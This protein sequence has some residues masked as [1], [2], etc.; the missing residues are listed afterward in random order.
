MS[1]ITN[2]FERM[3]QKQYESSK[4]PLVIG[5]ILFLL[6]GCV[7]LI[8]NH[9]PARAEPSFCIGLGTMLYGI[10]EIRFRG[11]PWRVPLLILSLVFWFGGICWFIRAIFAV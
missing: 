8:R 1:S 11:T 6:L 4:W 2:Y 7:Y 5:G 3:T 9:D 10:T